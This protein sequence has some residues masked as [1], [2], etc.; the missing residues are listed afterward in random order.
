MTHTFVL[1]DDTVLCRQMPDGWWPLQVQLSPDSN[2]LNEQAYQVGHVTLHES[3][4][5]S[6]WLPN[7]NGNTDNTPDGLVHTDTEAF[8]T[9]TAQATSAM[10]YDHAVTHNVTLPVI[11]ESGSNAFVPYRQLMTHLPVALSDQISQAIQLLSWQADT[12]FCSRCASPTVHANQGERAMVC[13]VCRLRQYPRVQPCVITAITR[14]NPMTGEMQILLA[15]HHRH[16]QPTMSPMYG[17]IAGF[18]EVGES[19]EHAVVREVAEEVHI[20]VSDIRYVSSQPW[21]FPSNLMLGFHASY[22]SGDI[23]IQEDEL[24]HADFFDLSNLPKIPPKGSIAH[25]L[26]AQVMREQGMPL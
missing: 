4:A 1:S 9:F 10:T 22:A 6:H 7:D 14:P 11:T 2:D 20:S 12:Q 25:E 24:A 18:V 26:I 17:L 21:P 23:I 13:P 19:L 15:H 3:L 8:N 16:G 5:P